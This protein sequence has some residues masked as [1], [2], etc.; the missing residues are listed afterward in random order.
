MPL[1]QTPQHLTV[2]SWEGGKIEGERQAHCL[3]V[4]HECI[5]IL[6]SKGGRVGGM[7]ARP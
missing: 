1:R 2:V 3:R 7:P 4:E 6:K 5:A